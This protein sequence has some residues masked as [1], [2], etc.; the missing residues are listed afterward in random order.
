[1]VKKD[2]EPFLCLTTS[3]YGFYDVSTVE[4]YGQF[5][6]SLNVNQGI[7]SKRKDSSYYVSTEGPEGVRATDVQ[8]SLIVPLQ[9]ADVIVTI[10]L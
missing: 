10:C 8:V 4:L 1:M 6:G 5:V 3:F 9:E 7:P 2:L